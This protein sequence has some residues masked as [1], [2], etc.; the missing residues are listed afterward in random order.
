MLEH[1]GK[2]GFLKKKFSLAVWEGLHLR[3]CIQKLAMSRQPGTKWAPQPI[4]MTLI[5]APESEVLTDYE[6]IKL[7][8]FA[9][10]FSGL[11]LRHTDVSKLTKSLV[12]YSKT[13]TQATEP[14][15]KRLV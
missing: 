7:T 15:S 8:S 10:V 5:R 1:L 6:I 14:S 3:S 12:R 13:L 2:E 4:P 9:N 11:V